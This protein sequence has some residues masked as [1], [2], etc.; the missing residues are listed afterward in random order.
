MPHT[1]VTRRSNCHTH[2]HTHTLSRWP[3]LGCDYGDHFAV[4]VELQSLAPQPQPKPKP[5]PDTAR[6]GDRDKAK[7]SDSDS[8]GG[9]AV[10]DGNGRRSS[11]P[12]RQQR[13]WAADALKRSF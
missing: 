8:D 9:D 10:G 7:G 13:Q 12:L 11:T 5:K 6:L 1:A 3:V 4:L 2:A